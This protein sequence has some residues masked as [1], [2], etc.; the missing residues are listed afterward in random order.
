[1]TI[2]GG[3]G[4]SQVFSSASGG[5]V[6]AYNAITTAP[7]TVVPANTSR[8]LITFHN[9]G[10]IDIF[11]APTTVIN[12]VTGSAVALVPSTAALGGCFRIFANG[13]SLIIGGECQTAWQA[14]S[15]SGSTNALTVMD[16]NQ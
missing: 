2:F 15:A 6:Y 10:T 13:G 16:S 5:K 1:M 8:T 7:A 4:A 9:P 3:V 11:V 14:F 12:P